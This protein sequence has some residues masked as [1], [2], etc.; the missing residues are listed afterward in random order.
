MSESERRETVQYP[1]VAANLLAMKEVDQKMRAD[2]TQE[3][4]DEVDIK[5]TAAMKE[6]IAQ[7]GWPTI[8][9]VGKDA[10][11]AAWLLVQ[12][13]DQEPGF[14]KECIALMER[15]PDTEVEKSLIAYLDDRIRV[16]TDQL[17]RY[18]TQFREE[19]DEDGKVIKY[20]PLPIE[21]LEHV[22]ERRLSMGLDTME[23]YTRKITE[24]YY[25]HLLG[26]E[27]R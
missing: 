19:Y 6:I 5:S 2:A 3:W 9:K 27:A 4:D 26:T 16:N 23:E 24:N 18:G 21:D 14:Q 25:P 1:D 20:E 8:S 10:A 17:Q 13:A 12:H 22:N 7:I 15:E 11:E